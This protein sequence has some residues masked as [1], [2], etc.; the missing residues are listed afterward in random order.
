MIESEKRLMQQ[1]TKIYLSL[2][3]IQKYKICLKIIRTQK[4]ANRLH[5]Q[6]AMLIGVRIASHL[7]IVTKFFHYSEHIIDYVV[8]CRIVNIEQSRMFVCMK[9]GFVH[10]PALI[11]HIMT[12]VVSISNNKIHPDSD[13]WHSHCSYSQCTQ[14]VSDVPNVKHETWKRWKTISDTTRTVLMYDDFCI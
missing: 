6:E 1:L 3:M 13:C 11:M 14:Y 4:E 8:V 12:D 5:Q 9:P 2:K 7:C 10:H